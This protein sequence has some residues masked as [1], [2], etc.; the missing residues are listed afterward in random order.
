MPEAFARWWA[1]QDETEIGRETFLVFCLLVICVATVM[2]GVPRMRVCGHDV[3]PG[4]RRGV[5]RSQRPATGS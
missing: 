2:L 5:A 3:F 4:T 1:D